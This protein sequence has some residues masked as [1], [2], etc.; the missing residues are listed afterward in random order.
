MAM[1][2]TTQTALPTA[3]IT[4]STPTA[5]P[6]TSSSTTTSSDG[7]SAGAIGGIVASLVVAA[8]IALSMLAWFLLRRRKQ[9]FT[10]MTESPPEYKPGF[11]EGASGHS[12]SKDP[13][14]MDARTSPVELSITHPVVELPGQQTE[15]RSV[16]LP[17]DRG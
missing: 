13:N 2:Q 8:L 11:G 9:N 16:E 3:S 4:I 5:D 17:A 1:S 6:P 10:H 14:E 7:L 12:I 15:M